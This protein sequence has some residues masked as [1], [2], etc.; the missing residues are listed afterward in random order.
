MKI[1]NNFKW[2]K[3]CKVSWA[4]L[5]CLNPNGHMPPSGEQVVFRF[6]HT[7]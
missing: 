6:A 4:T 1:K 5:Y 2:Y 3:Q 7:S